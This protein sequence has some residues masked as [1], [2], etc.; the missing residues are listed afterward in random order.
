M[1]VTLLAHFTT[2]EQRDSGMRRLRGISALPKEL[3]EM[4]MYNIY[5]CASHDEF[6]YPKG[7][8]NL[9][10]AKVRQQRTRLWS[11]QSSLLG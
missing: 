7:D 8:H 6:L 9:S 1:F 10:S 3:F 4:Y 5:L 2:T 11:L